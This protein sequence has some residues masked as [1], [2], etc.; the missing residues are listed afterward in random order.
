M[1]GPTDVIAQ[2]GGDT[3]YLYECPRGTIAIDAT[4]DAN[5]H[6]DRLPLSHETRGPARICGCFV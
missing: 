2:V 6:G 1:H 5:N 4:P 3:R